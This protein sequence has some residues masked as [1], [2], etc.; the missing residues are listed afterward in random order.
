MAKIL[1]VEDDLVV[2][3]TL[4][5]LLESYAFEVLEAGHGDEGLE[6]F[7]KNEID[8]VVTDLILPHKDGLEFIRELK[9]D[10][11]QAKIIAVSAGIHNFT[12]TAQFLLP[13]AEELGAHKVLKKPYSNE[14]L[15]SVLKDS[16]G[17]A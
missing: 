3:N 1:I 16:I 14:E 9:I 4:K 8:L 15:V 17:L 7:S 12:N 5:E 2:R 6:I 10:H 13:M 11:P